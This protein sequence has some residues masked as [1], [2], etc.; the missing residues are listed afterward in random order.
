MHRRKA[1]ILLSAT[2]LTAQPKPALES[3]RFEAATFKVSA[4]NLRGGG[5][6]PL[7]GGQRYQATNLTVRV[8][9]QVAYHLKAEQVVGGPD[10]IDTERFDMN[11]VAAGPSTIDELHAMLVNLLVDEMK[12]KFHRDQKE[13]PIYALT[14][15]KQGPK[16]LTPAPARNSGDTW[17][18]VTPDPAPGAFLRATWQAR[19]C[20]MEYFA[21]RLG[22]NLDRPVVDQTGI[23]GDH[24][25]KLTYTRE[26]P[27]N[28]QPGAL[29]NG[30]ELDT[31]GP[32]IFEAL[33]KQLGLKLEKQ[34]GKVPIL[35]IEHAEK[36]ASLEVP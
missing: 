31:S 4:P 29:I 22:Q 7:P 33:Q 36:P 8:L 3:M 28:G 16:N 5:I 1:L 27:P 17:I 2:L 9:I 34:R 35:V 19:F 11:A 20:P 30:V 24:D 26:A 21:Y 25:F 12:L 10:W 32:T 15:D 6:R 14:V 23:R 13:L 18:E